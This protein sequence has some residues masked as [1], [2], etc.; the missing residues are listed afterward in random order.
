MNKNTWIIAVVVAIVFGGGGFWGGMTYAQSQR[1]S[2]GGAGG[3]AGRAGGAAAV[4]TGAGA[5][6]GATFGT[7]LSVSPT[8]ITI[9][10][11][12]ATTT[13]AAS[14]TKIVLYDTSTQVQELQSVSVSNLAAGQTVTVMGTANSDGSITAQ[15]IQVRP[16][17]RTGAPMIPASQ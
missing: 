13:S 9:Q 12:T 6:S 2:F 7:I 10:L 16:A 15:T 4:R 17:G 3:F 5:G 11:P 14:G 1:S 8:S